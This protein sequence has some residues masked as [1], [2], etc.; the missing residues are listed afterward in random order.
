MMMADI[1]S[2]NTICKSTNVWLVPN[3]DIFTLHCKSDNTGHRTENVQCPDTRFPAPLIYDKNTPLTKTNTLFVIRLNIQHTF[4]TTKLYVVG[5]QKE[6]SQWDVSFDHTQP[7]WKL[8]GKIL[9][10]FT[11]IICFCLELWPIKRSKAEK[12]CNECVM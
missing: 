2:N 10:R 9:T 3:L 8:M 1:T 4:L 7:M 6:Q 5:N 12:D 11:V